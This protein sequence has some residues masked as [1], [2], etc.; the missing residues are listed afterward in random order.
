MS[1]RQGYVVA[2]VA[3]AVL[4][5][6]VAAAQ[7][8]APRTPWGD[9]DLGGVW[10]FRTLT[11]LERPEAQADREFLTE[12]EV[13]EIERGAEDT[14]RTADAAEAVR[15]EAGGNVGAYNRF[16]LDFGTNVVEDGRTSLIVDP[17]NGRRPPKTPEGEARP[18]FGGSF[19]T[20]PFEQVEDLNYFDRCIGSAALPIYPTAYNN[21]VQ[22]FQTPDHVAMFVEMMGST[23][24]IPLDRRPH[25]EI[26]QW[27]GD[28]R[29]HWEG[30]TL[31]VETTNFDRALLLI[32]GSRDARLLVER[33][34]RVG[35]VIEY[36]FTVDDPTT[37]TAPWTAVQSLRKTD[38]PLF[39]YACHEGNYAAANILAGARQ[40]EA[41]EASGTD[42]TGR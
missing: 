5:P 19:G 42:Q 29:G 41:A 27:L 28:S 33:F 24:I 16:W 35:D 34:T 30:V 10:D 17:P 18:G 12:E 38:A 21:N 1:A 20:G 22:L 31:V 4:T 8:T 11:P 14:N 23:R 36:S 13:A 39:E 15:T 32:G 7:A 40:T 3:L 26:R 37:W 2:L 6:L 25:G 9:P